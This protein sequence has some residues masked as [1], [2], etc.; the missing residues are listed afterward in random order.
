MDCLGMGYC[1]CCEGHYPED[2]LIEFKG[3]RICPGCFEDYTRNCFATGQR[4]WTNT[5]EK[6][7]IRLKED[8]MLVVAY[9]KSNIFFNEDLNSVVFKAKPKR[10]NI[11]KMWACYEIVINEDDLTDLGRERLKKLIF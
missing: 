3:E 10:E 4:E 11:G 6:F 1:S 7:Y 9:M 8:N 2:E 5:M